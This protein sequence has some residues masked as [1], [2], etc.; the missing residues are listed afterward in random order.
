M[1]TITKEQA[2]KRIWDSN[3]QVF[4]CRFIKRT[5]NENGVR[6]VREGRFRLGPTVTKGLAGGPAAYN[7]QEKNLIPAYRMAGDQSESDGKRRSIPIE[8][9]QSLTID[10]ITYDVRN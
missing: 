3:G 9:L 10:G 8:G 4:A 1:T 5:P 6:E 2:A 7:F